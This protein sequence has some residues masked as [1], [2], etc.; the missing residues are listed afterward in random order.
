VPAIPTCVRYRVRPA[1]CA[2]FPRLVAEKWRLCGRLGL[3][4]ARRLLLAGDAPAGT[5]IELFEWVG[6]AAMERAH[7]S[8]EVQAVWEELDRATE[9]GRGEG[10]EVVNGTW[11]LPPTSWPDEPLCADCGEPLSRCTCT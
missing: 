6:P 7:R 1:A 10:I 8:P 2:D 4:S 3:I 9:G 11:A 5:F